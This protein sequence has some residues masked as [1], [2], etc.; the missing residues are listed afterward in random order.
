MPKTKTMMR[1]NLSDA[2][3]AVLLKTVREEPDA[4]KL[5]GPYY[6]RSLLEYLAAARQ[7]I[8]ELK[9]K[10]KSRR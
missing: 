7:E 10:G 3:I 8:R 1:P 9:A 6:Y 2:D 5:H 4:R